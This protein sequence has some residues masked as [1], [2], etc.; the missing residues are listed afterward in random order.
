MEYHLALL[1]RHHAYTLTSNTTSNVAKRKSIQGF[2]LL[3]YMGMG[4]YLA[5]LWAAGT[6]LLGQR[7]F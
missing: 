5:G 7:T 1:S 6:P 2:P 3:S 4:L